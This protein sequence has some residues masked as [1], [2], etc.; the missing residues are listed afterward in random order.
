LKPKDPTDATSKHN[1][2]SFS[3]EPEVLFLTLP[4][5]IESFYALL[6]AELS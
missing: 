4:F 6:D 2:L 1:A 5:L 3:L